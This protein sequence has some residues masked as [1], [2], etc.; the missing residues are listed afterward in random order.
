MASSKSRKAAQATPPPKPERRKSSKPPKLPVPSPSSVKAGGRKR[1]KAAPV[2]TLAPAVVDPSVGM[3]VRW[4]KWRERVRDWYIYGLKAGEIQGADVSEPEPT[5]LRLAELT[6]IPHPTIKGW[7]E[8]GHWGKARA[9]WRESIRQDKFFAAR[10]QILDK[11][12]TFDVALIDVG[13]RAVQQLRQSLMNGGLSTRDVATAMVGARKAQDLVNIAANRPV[14]GSGDTP[15]LD[16]SLV[17]APTNTLWGNLHNAR[18]LGLGGTSAAQAAASA[19]D[20][21]VDSAL[22][23]SL[24]ELS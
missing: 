24:P 8:R 13:A 3:R 5:L 18:A 14:A 20:D 19:E 1:A 12:V 22:L 23:Q 15:R 17:K 4:A 9:S 21:D 10:E 16:A 6:K 2:E 7:A 11:L